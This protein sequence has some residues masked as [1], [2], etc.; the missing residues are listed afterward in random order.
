VIYQWESSPAGTNNWSNFGSQS[1]SASATITTQ[2]SSTD[3][4]CRIIIQGS[5]STNVISTVVTIVYGTAYCLPNV[6]SCS[7]GN[8]IDTFILDGEYGTQIYDTA[9]GCATNGYDNR[10][11]ETVSLF[12]G[13]YCPFIISTPASNLYGSIWIDFNDDF[14]FTTSANE[15]VW[16][17][18]LTAAVAQETGFTMPSTATIGVHRMRVV[19]FASSMSGASC[20]P[21][22]PSGETHDYTVNIVPYVGKSYTYD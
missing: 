20:A 13:V 14:S 12:A 9:T 22:N 1:A 6:Y 18:S 19:I 17:G 3:Y 11:G 10:T 2:T 7:S 21:S 5:T 4:R 16:T 15:Q 8:M